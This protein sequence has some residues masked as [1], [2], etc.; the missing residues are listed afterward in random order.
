MTTK[1]SKTAQNFDK[2]SNAKLIGFSLAFLSLTVGACATSTYAW[3]VVST[4]LIAGNISMTYK[5]SDIKI[6]LL[7]SGAPVYP[8][9]VDGEYANLGNTFLNYDPN[10]DILSPVSSMYQNLWLGKQSFADT[11]PK[12]R[13][14]YT[15]ASRNYREGDVANGGFLQYDCAFYSDK[16]MYVYLDGEETKITPASEAN[17]RNAAR[18]NTTAA[19]MDSVI[20]CLRVSFYSLSPAGNEQF[21]IYEPGVSASSDLPLGGRLNL[22]GNSDDYFDFDSSGK[23]IM[24]GDYNYDTAKLVYNE[25]G[26]VNT[27]SG[28]I[29]A[30]NAKTSPKV[31]DPLNIQ[32]SI[33]TGGLVIQHEKTYTLSELSAMNSAGDPI[34]PLCYITAQTYQRV[35]ISIYLEGWD[36][37]MNDS[38]SGAQFNISLAFSGYLKPMGA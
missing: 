25:A 33:A 16:N 21:M 10:N 4:S 22:L 32:D 2:R 34:R 20:K 14:S 5:A 27:V 23:E 30:F 18:F 15:S 26:R 38:I 35:V 19:Q 11:L 31:T 28:E 36:P 13:S 1:R 37:D 24:F 6:G 8:D 7:K 12:F 29:T 9:E 17:A 3:Y